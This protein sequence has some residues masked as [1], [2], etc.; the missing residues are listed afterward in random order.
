MREYGKVNK[1]PGYC[2]RTCLKIKVL[3]FAALECEAVEGGEAEAED[4]G[5]VLGGG[6]AHVALPA[7]AGVL[8]G[9]LGHQVVAVGLGQNRGGGDA[10]I[11][12]VT[13]HYGMGGNVHHRDGVKIWLEF[14]AV[15]YDMRG[16]HLEGVK[17]A[18]HSEDGGVQDIYTVNL[19][20]RHHVHGPRQSLLLD[21]GAQSLTLG[22]VELFGIVE[23]GVFEVGGEYYCRTAD[24]PAQASASGLV[25]AG[26]G[27]VG[28][29]ERQQSQDRSE[30]RGQS[31]EVIIMTSDE[32]RGNNK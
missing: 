32:W 18:V 17:S 5:L 13:L 31:D 15:H 27:Y 1:N 3:A 23:A 6:I 8:R 29:H 21:D 14:V 9:Q 4:G 16:A 10:E 24:R 20:V 26:F 25:A 28:N 19:V 30:V 11:F 2:N 22:G 12:A 7:V